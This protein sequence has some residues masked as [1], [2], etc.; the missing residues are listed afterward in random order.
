MDIITENEEDL[1]RMVTMLH[2]DG[3]R[4]NNEY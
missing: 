1:E 3:K 2:D 4:S